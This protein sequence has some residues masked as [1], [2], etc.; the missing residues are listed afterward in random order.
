MLKHP[1]HPVQQ[2]IRHLSFT[3]QG[4]FFCLAF[5]V[6]Q[7]YPVGINAEATIGGGNIIGGDQI[8]LFV[9]QFLPGIFHMFFSLGCKAN[10]EEVTLYLSQDIW[11]PGQLQSQLF[12]GDFFLY[13]C[14]GGALRLVVGTAAT[15]ISAS[16]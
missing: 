13:F 10:L 15:I 6:N 9:S 2:L 12:A 16:V 1:H 14:L 8:K 11:R 4:Q 3:H 7:S 5:L